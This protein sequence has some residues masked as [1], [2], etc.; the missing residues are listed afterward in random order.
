MVAIK[1]KDKMNT[2]INKT[3]INNSNTVVKVIPSS[4]R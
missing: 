3:F 2:N 1:F 4:N